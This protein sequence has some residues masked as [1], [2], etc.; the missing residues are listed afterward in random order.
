MRDGWIIY[1]AFGVL[2]CLLLWRVVTQRSVNGTEAGNR[3]ASLVMLGVVTLVMVVWQ[4][5]RLLPH[6][7]DKTITVFAA[8]SLTHLG[9][10]F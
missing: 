7:E 1:A 9:G 3:R 10:R 6:P 8:A 4:S 5:A 2:A